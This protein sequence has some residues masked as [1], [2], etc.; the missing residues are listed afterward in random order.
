MH[1][2]WQIVIFFGMSVLIFRSYSV[3]FQEFFF[4]F[5]FFF[6]KSFLYN[7]SYISY[8]VALIFHKLFM[9]SSPNLGSN[10]QPLN[11][12]IFPNTIF[13]FFFFFF[14]FTKPFLLLKI[15]IEE[16]FDVADELL[17]RYR[18]SNHGTSCPLKHFAD[19][20]LY[21]PHTFQPLKL[22]YK[23]LLVKMMAAY[24]SINGSTV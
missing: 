3:N 13:F 11:I 20:L 16:S 24:I 22:L 15:S 23:F 1:N 19:S 6:Q 14:F 21:F 12:I 18:I 10:G 8:I 4:F 5:F 7:H 2:V 9:F 17:W